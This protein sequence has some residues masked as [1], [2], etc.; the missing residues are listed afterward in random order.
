MNC[1]DTNRL[2]ELVAGGRDDVELQDHLRACSSCQAELRLIQELP[3]AFRPEFE[4][5]EALVQRVMSGL[6]EAP[7]G[8]RGRIPGLQL[9][10][11]CVLGTLTALATI[12]ATG[13]MGAGGPVELLAFSL[14]AGLAAVL[15]QH[16]AASPVEVEAS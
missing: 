14:V 2:I 16:R 5:P 15:M 13:S 8:R 6:A 7:T 4:V 10:A 12:V 1:P 3:A 9:V 11:A